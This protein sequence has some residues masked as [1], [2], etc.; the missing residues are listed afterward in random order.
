MADV[1]VR[2]GVSISTVSRA[3]GGVPGVSEATRV[4]IR[5]IADELAYVVS[6]EASHLA[7]GSTGRV[8]V[9]V[10]AIHLWYFSSVVAG[11]EAVLRE[12]ELDLLL[13]HVG[14]PEDRRRFFDRLP[15]RRKVDALV[16]VALPMT[17]EQR[18]RLD[19]LGVALVFAGATSEDHPWVAIDD[20]AAAASA[21]NHLVTLGHERIAMIRTV[22]PDG[23]DWQADRGRLAGFREA[24]QRGGLPERRDFVVTV[25]WGPDGGARAM[26]RLLALPDPPTGV[27]AY[28]DEVAI[29]ALRSL[30]R[31][32]VDVPGAV[33]LVGLDDHPMADLTDLT[34]VAQFPAEIGRRAAAVVLRTLGLPV[35]ADL[36]GVGVDGERPGTTLVVRGT[37]APPRAA[38]ARLGLVPSTLGG[39]S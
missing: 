8:G 11:L 26:D 21:V 28:S 30:R 24:L 25:P 6:P 32:R 18:R 34:T 3:L 5:A 16:V 14:G 23:G 10:P 15:A 22:E 31:A 29:G 39:S 1:A 38:G 36:D 35:P 20:A 7:R 37:T 2:A 4:R 17:D 19:E 9:V 12:S 13:Y 33:S 27:F